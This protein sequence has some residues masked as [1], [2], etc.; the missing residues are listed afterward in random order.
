MTAVNQ[1]SPFKSPLPEQFNGG[2]CGDFANFE[3][4]SENGPQ[5]SV[6]PQCS[7]NLSS[8]QRPES[9]HIEPK[10]NELKKNVE[11]NSES[12]CYQATNGPLVDSGVYSSNVSPVQHIES[13]G[14][15]KGQVHDSE[16]DNSKTVK[17]ETSHELSK[18]LQDNSKPVVEE[19]NKQ[20]EEMLSEETSVH[21]N[22]GMLN[23]ETSIH[24]NAS[25]S[26]TQENNK[27]IAD[28]ETVEQNDSS[29][30]SIQCIPP[31]S[32]PENDNVHESESNQS[33]KNLVVETHENEDDS[34]DVVISNCDE[35]HCENSNTPGS[36][37]TENSNFNSVSSVDS[38]ESG[39]SQNVCQPD[40]DEDMKDEILQ[41]DTEF[42]TENSANFKDSLDFDQSKCNVEESAVSLQ[43]TESEADVNIVS[44]KAVTE[45]DGSLAEIA[46]NTSTEGEKCSQIQTEIVTEADISKQN[47]SDKIN[48]SVRS[49][50]LEEHLTENNNQQESAELKQTETNMLSSCSESKDDVKN[51]T[52]S[53]ETSDTEMTC[54]NDAF[55]DN[56]L[57]S[58]RT[59][60][61]HEFSQSTNVEPLENRDNSVTSIDNHLNENTV[62]VTNT[63]TILN[64]HDLSDIN[65]TNETGTSGGIED[66]GNDFGDFNTTGIDAEDD[67][68]D[69]NASFNDKQITVNNVNEVDDEFGDFNSSFEKKHGVCDS[70]ADNTGEKFGDFNAVCDENEEQLGEDFGDFNATFD[71]MPTASDQTSDDW[72]AFSEP[73]IADSNKI[74]DEEDKWAGFEEEDSSAGKQFEDVTSQNKMESEKVPPSE[75]AN[76]VISI[77]I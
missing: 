36:K 54:A 22:K 34:A 14:S 30:E 6:N 18:N 43:K 72:A 24:E 28:S 66:N 73:Q 26:V 15:D 59:E 32:I 75:F 4:H 33:E 21:E 19:R 60:T 20:S 70:D 46:C 47:E 76:M 25:L 12:D 65:A 40:Y 74:E 35:S 11:T 56:E 57:Q 53:A 8:E 77:F 49:E 5:E 41:N 7:K 45:E 1:D 69:F 61:D 44:D 37:S 38:E 2:Q 63:N 67:F 23:E 64:D 17:N 42:P 9:I 39:C 58:G 51:V 50:E 13:S 29:K 27:D 31:A 68:G 52:K 16:E 71:S 62:P 3:T 10:S 55:S 48:K